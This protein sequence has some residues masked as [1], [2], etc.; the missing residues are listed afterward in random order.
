MQ[1]GF[2]GLG[3]MGYN[4]ALN[5]HRHGYE[6]VAYD[7]V[8]E[9]VKNI[10]LEGIAPAYSLGEMCQ[11]LEGRIV[12]WL[13]VPAGKPVDDCIEALLPYLAPNDI[14]IDGAIP[15][16]TIP[17]VVINTLNPT[18]LTIWTAVQAAVWKVLYWAPV[19]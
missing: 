17:Y 8:T 9:N 7:V 16:L 6:V 10:L 5:L 1:I 18:D 11:Q 14:V 2:V 13:M 4:L 12:V 19:Q 15:I 3:K